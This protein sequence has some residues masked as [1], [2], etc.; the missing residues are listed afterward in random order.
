MYNLWTILNW[1]FENHRSEENKY[2]ISSTCTLV[3]LSRIQMC[4]YQR[5]LVMSVQKHAILYQHES[6]TLL[7]SY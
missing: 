4:T 1:L 7:P 2:I 5:Q 3:I 6:E